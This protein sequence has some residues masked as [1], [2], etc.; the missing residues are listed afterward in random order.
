[1][2]K[3]DSIFSDAR[4]KSYAQKMLRVM[5]CFILNLFQ[6]LLYVQSIVFLDYYCNSII[7]RVN[8][9]I[10]ERQ[11]NCSQVFDVSKQIFTYSNC[12]SNQNSFPFPISQRK[13]SFLLFPLICKVKELSVL[14][15]FKRMFNMRAFSAAQPLSKSDFNNIMTYNPLFQNQFLQEVVGRVVST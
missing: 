1:M 3:Q 10:N 12:P 9:H 4:N 13:Y 5:V 15:L 11:Q 8:P 2:L 14:F 7:S 6:E